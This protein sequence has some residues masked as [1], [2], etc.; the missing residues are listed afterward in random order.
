MTE[1]PDHTG[2]EPIPDVHIQSSVKDIKNTK[3]DKYMSFVINM[4][5]MYQS[6]HLSTAQ[7]RRVRTYKSCLK[8]HL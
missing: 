5:I 4:M 1:P 6:H 8:A 7:K 2:N 3:N